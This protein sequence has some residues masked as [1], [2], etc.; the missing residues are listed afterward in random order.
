MAFSVVAESVRPALLLDLGESQ[1]ILL[2]GYLRISVLGPE[3]STG[4]TKVEL[5]VPSARHHQNFFGE[6]R[7]YLLKTGRR[8]VRSQFTSDHYRFLSQEQGGKCNG[9]KQDLSAV[10]KVELD[11]YIPLAFGGPDGLSN[12]QLLCRDCNRI[13]GDRPMAYLTFALEQRYPE[14]LDASVVHRPP[15]RRRKKA[16]APSRQYPL[17]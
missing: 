15:H 14:G 16:P 8:R 3:R 17:F 9:C 7:Y 13:K 5:T 1:R 10:T 11:H 12:W 2:H 6:T 4:Q